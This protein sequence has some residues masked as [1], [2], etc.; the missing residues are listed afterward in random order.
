MQ[1]S[2]EAAIPPRPQGAEFPR[3]KSHEAPAQNPS[4]SRMAKKKTALRNGFSLQA[5][6][7]G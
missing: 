1:E 6:R 7:I 3:R 2:E 5:G 4:I